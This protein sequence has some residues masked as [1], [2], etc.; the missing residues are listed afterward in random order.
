MSGTI[1]AKGTMPGSVMLKTHGPTELVVRHITIQPGGST[2]WHYHPGTLLAVVQ[3]G[4]L[5]HI[6]ADCQIVTYPAGQSL[7]EP[8]GSHH[9]HVGRNLGTEPVEL[10]VTYVNPV[11]SPLSVDAPDPGCDDDPGTNLGYSPRFWLAWA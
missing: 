8:S 1:L 2:G 3:R 11:G 7:V 5:T 6:D 10:Y 9:V 4:T